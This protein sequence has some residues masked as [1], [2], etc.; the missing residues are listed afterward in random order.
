MRD[1][2]KGESRPTLSYLERTLCSIRIE[3]C[4]IPPYQNHH[5]L[6]EPSSGEPVLPNLP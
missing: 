2:E 6:G 5:C 4:I 1:L 3:T